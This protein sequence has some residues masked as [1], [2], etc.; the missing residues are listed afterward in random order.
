ML[1]TIFGGGKKKEVDESDEIP[2]F[3]LKTLFGADFGLMNIDLLETLGT[4]TFGRVRLV[5]SLIDKKYYALKMM[6]KA[7]IVKLKQLEHIQNEVKIMSKLRCIYAVEMFA[8][9]QDDHSL[10]ML[11]EYIP[12]GELFTH[13]RR[14]TKF[15]LVLYKFYTIEIVCAI[16]YLHSLNIAYRDIKPENILIHR[17]GHI[18]IADFGFAK[19]VEDRTFTLCGTPEYLA[20]ETIL[21]TGHGTAV[22]W[23]A[24]GILLFEMAC[25][26]PP[27]Y[28]TNPFTVYKKIIDGKIDY[29]L[30]LHVTT[31]KAISGFLTLKVF[32]RLGSGKGG[33]NSIKK[34]IFFLDIDWNAASRELITPPIVPTVISD[35][36][37]SNFDVYPEEIAEEASNLTFE[38]RNMFKDFDIMLER[39]VQL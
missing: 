38:E 24:I 29:P 34:N 10:Y 12:G 26:F 32:N 20:P 25:G 39:P 16:K 19:I 37:S 6:K 1:S 9:F 13:L 5:R 30:L 3:S 31:R 33:F 36:D 7:R 15:D 4:G 27:F 22:D 2:D 28:G 11:L 8:M 23:W 35:G 18:R 14:Q 21:G 17:N